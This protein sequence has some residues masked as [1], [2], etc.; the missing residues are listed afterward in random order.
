MTD[1]I[2]IVTP[3]YVINEGLKKMNDEC[4]RTLTEF[5][6]GNYQLILVDD[7]SPIEWDVEGAKI[8]RLPENRGYSYATNRGL[9]V[10]TGEI[11]I[12]GNNDLI[13]EE[14]WLDA[15]L[16]PFDLGYEVSTVW[17]SD[18]DNVVLTERIEENPKFGALFAMKR[19]VYERVGGFDELFR[20]RFSDTDLRRR[21][22]DEG[23]KI[24]KN[25]NYVVKHHAR[26][27]EL[28]RDPDDN[29]FLRGQRLYE[30]KWGIAE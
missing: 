6:P 1:S 19:D 27:T 2:S 29:D 14:G 25:L 10:A 17:T 5:T 28:A 18:Q 12:L 9:E 21:M 11:I 16:L 23:I 3:C 7:G 8:I 26:V 24:G 20:G 15:L 22:M 4:F 13:F 30:S